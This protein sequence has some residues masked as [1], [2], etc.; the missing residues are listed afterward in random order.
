MIVKN[1]SRVIRDTLQNL[2]DTLPITTWI[3]SDTGSTDGTQDIIKTFFTTRGLSGELHEDAWVDFGT[4]RS[5]VLSYAYKKS[6]YVLMWDADDRIHGNIILPATMNAD[7]YIFLFRAGDVQFHRSQLFNNQKR[8]I[9]KGVLHEI[10]E[11]LDRSNTHY[12]LEGSYY[13]SSNHTGARSNDPEKYL[14]DALILEKAYNTAIATKDAIAARYAFYCA[15]SYRDTSNRAKAIEFYKHTLELNGWSQEKYVACMNLYDQ[16]NAAGEPEQG[17]S[18]LMESTRYDLTR[19]ECVYRLVKYYACK[20]L[21]E[22]AYACYGMIQS[23]YETEYLKDTLST[24]LF[25]C[26]EEYGFYLPY[27]MI[28]VAERKK[29]YKLGVKMYTIIWTKQV[30]GIN[31]WF[32]NNLIHNLQFFVGSFSKNPEL[33]SL[34]DRWCT[35]MKEP[36]LRD[37]R[38]ILTKVRRALSIE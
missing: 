10:A 27:F 33:L 20:E 26:I 9:Y 14:K 21:M 12:M 25:A 38:T 37:H 13:A 6:N 32:L 1:E 22:P 34:F 3:I 31:E 16:Y 19:V 28:I 8:W 15:N 29:I 11:C 36:L 4:N 30:P 23:W 5:L 2:C 7:E 17:V 24:R 18:Y 35:M